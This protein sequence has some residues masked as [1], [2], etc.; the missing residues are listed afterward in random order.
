MA[1]E[2][3]FEG[4]A[5]TIPVQFV[6]DALTK[7]AN[8]ATFENAGRL[9]AFLS[10]VVE[11]SLAGRAHLIAGKTIAAD[12]YGREPDDGSNSIVRVDA[13]RLRRKLAAY[14]GTEGAS[15]PV[16]IH[17]D[18]GGYA[19]RFELLTPDIGLANAENDTTGT[20]EAQLA[21]AQTDPSSNRRRALPG[22]V[23][24]AGVF[25]IGLAIWLYGSTN[26]PDDLPTVGNNGPFDKGVT[27]TALAEKSSA[28]LQSANLAEK[29]SELLFPIADV[30]HQQLA[31]DMYRAAIEIDPS[32]SGGYA[33][34]AHS[35]GTLS[36]ISPDPG[37]SAELRS[38]GAQLAKQAINLD[39]LS[40]WSHSAAAWI[41][42]ADR[43]YDEALA[44]S[45]RAVSLSPT[46]GKVLDFSAAIAVMTGNF[47]EGL[48]LSD[49]GH[50]RDNEERHPAYLNVYGVA[51]YH[52]GYDRRAI[53]AFD[54][55]VRMG[56]PVSELTLMY[57]AAAAQAA[58]E[59]SAAASLLDELRKTWPAF[60]PAPVA[61]RF[62]Q[63]PADAQKLLSDLEA[64]G[65]SIEP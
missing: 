1:I 10:Y 14:Y 6:R 45:R 52:L 60:R 15:D 9:Q 23:A 53:E 31:T 42:L 20:S 41:A 54:S 29:A 48:A 24:I 39:P 25:A 17:V 27:R 4:K 57:K 59:A 61:N 49:P 2:H 46:D 37:I 33:G 65:W 62:Y 38:E 50:P 40:G 30:K 35:L 18:S 11:E 7:I 5:P 16:R 32:F 36:L 44:L 56:G 12:V 47:E 64:A 63:H 58:G 19:P 13:G 43:D 28:T 3:D 22:V 8:S 55:A 34:A 51:C 21:T 26:G